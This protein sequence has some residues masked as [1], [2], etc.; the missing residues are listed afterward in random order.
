[1]ATIG[2]KEKKTIIDDNKKHETDTGSSNVQIALLSE[3]INHLV[4][5]LKVH[6]K[7]HHC[8]RGLLCL[9]G[10]RSRLL[11]Y[12][13]RTDFEAYKKLTEKLELKTKA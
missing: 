10:Q 11:T 1:M 12:L 5:H 2:T 8:R 6:K 7:D 3:R 4:E 9:V 13:K